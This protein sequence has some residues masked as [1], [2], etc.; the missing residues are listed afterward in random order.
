MVGRYRERDCTAFRRRTTFAH[1]KTAR[2]TAVYTVK[3]GLAAPQVYRLFEDSRGNVWVSTD[4]ASSGRPCALGRERP[5][6]MQQPAGSPG[7]R[8]CKDDWAAR[9]FGEDAAGNVW[10]GFDE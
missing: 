6:R 5:G 2:P 10:I 7:S 4:F 8:R 3:D 1:L 9:S